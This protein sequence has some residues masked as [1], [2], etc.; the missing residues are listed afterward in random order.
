[1][2]EDFRAHPSS[3]RSP[4][5]LYNTLRHKLGGKSWHVCLEAGLSSP[6]DCRT[7][8]DR[9]G[10]GEASDVMSGCCLFTPDHCFLLDCP[11]SHSCSHEGAPLHVSYA[12]LEE[13]LHPH[14]PTTPDTCIQKGVGVS[15]LGSQ[16][17]GGLHQKKQ[18]THNPKRKEKPYSIRSYLNDFNTWQNNVT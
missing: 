2:R 4:V 17:C 14:K 3:L 15:K 7:G 12:L 9:G 6:V 13:G 1:M 10:E 11:R 18:P 5:F 16:C 8:K